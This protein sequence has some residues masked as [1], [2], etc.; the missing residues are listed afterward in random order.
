LAKSAQ[1]SGRAAS[2]SAKSGD[3]FVYTL[4]STPHVNRSR[5]D[6]LC[7]LFG[8]LDKNDIRYC[9]LHSY[10]ELPETLSSDLDIAVHPADAARV[11]SLYRSLQQ[12]GYRV[13]QV[14]NYFVNAYYFVFF[15]TDGPVIN[16]AAV[17]IILEHRRG[18]LIAPTGQSLVS[19]RRKQRMYWVPAPEAEF[20]YLLA[21]KTWKG[22]APP[23]QASRLKALVEQLGQPTAERLAGHLFQSQLKVRVVE[24][25]VNGQLNELL[26][27]IRTQTWKTSFWQNP[28]RLGAY[29]LSDICRRLRRWIQPTG[30]F[31]TFMGL[32]GVGKST[33]IRQVVSV[34]SPAFRRQRVFHWRPNVLW[35]R[36][37]A[38]DTSQPHRCPE[39]SSWLSVA[40]V[41]AYVLD[42]WVGYWFVIRPFL[43]RSGLVVFDRH[44]DDLLIDAKRYR[45]G[46]PL[47]A[48]QVL[49]CLIP[50][51]DLILILDAPTEVIL[52]RKQ[53]VAVEE[54]QRQ[55]A[56]YVKYH[57]DTPSSQ[58][59]DASAPVARVT[60]DA[61][62]AILEYLAQR[63]ERRHA[64]RLLQYRGWS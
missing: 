45:Y 9:V 59:I 33:L 38:G 8:G 1:E 56:L 32:D 52:S 57:H 61:S 47:W 51:P 58:L 46:G 48:I 28:F 34:V 64:G 4:N 23:Q 49:R 27:K 14:L 21:K 5:T 44:F 22:T 50:K 20:T 3:L 15:W 35:R 13:I 60:S 42:Y 30:L 62:Q 25:C 29:V 12:Q 40:K 7:A 31:V 2:E 39:R 16:S 19:G 6:F 43:A 26:G 41:L 18:G 55:T 37:T 17:D 10:G 63:F 24:A 11:L 54:V 53:E 36:K